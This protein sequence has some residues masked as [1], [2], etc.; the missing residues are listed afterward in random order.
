MRGPLALVLALLLG[1]AAGCASV[2]RARAPAWLPRL[3]PFQGPVGSDVVHMEVA[4]LERPLGD[5]YINEELWQLAD[6]RV[7][8]PERRA[9]M[10]GSGFRVGQVS[11]LMTPPG[12]LS[13]LTSKRSCVNPRGVQVRAGHATSVKL[14]PTAATCRFHL[15][16][17]GQDSELEFHQAELR[18]G[19]VASLLKN[20]HTR[21]R[22]TPQVIHGEIMGT[23]RPADDRSGWLMDTRRPKEDFTAFSW[24]ACLAPNEYLVIGGKYDKPETLGHQCFVRPEEATP[25][26]RLLVI[27]CS[28]VKPTTTPAALSGPA[29]EEDSPDKGVPLALQA[30]GK[31]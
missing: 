21:L 2:E 23:Y 12:L 19:V 18:L 9:A 27:R 30:A 1:M 17:D 13:L 5:P 26:Q 31:P 10:D 15:E 16:R 28:T 22:F 24:E 3:N 7:I 6:E 11:G 25:V 14:A 8:S 29:G 20:G 4:L